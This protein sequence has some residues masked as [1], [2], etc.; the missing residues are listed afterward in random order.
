MPLSDA[1]PP[2]ETAEERAARVRAAVDGLLR[3]WADGEAIDFEAALAAQPDLMPE[4][5][6]QVRA[7][8]LLA[9]AERQAASATADATSAAAS[10]AAASSA[11]T[12]WADGASSVDAVDA[13]ERAGRAGAAPL[14][15]GRRRA[16]LAAASTLHAAELPPDSGLRIRCPHCR[17]QVEVLDEH[18]WD[19]I[20][21]GTCGSVFSLVNSAPA[22]DHVQPLKVLGHFELVSRLGVGSFGSVWQARDVELDRLVAV[23]IPRRGQ[24][25]PLG[26]AQFLREARVAAQLRHP[27]IVRVYEVGRDGDLLYIVSD[28]VRG[29]TLTQWLEQRRPTVREAAA[30]AATIADALEHAHQQG[31][32][33]RDLKPANILIDEQGAPQITDFG[34]AK[35][36]VGEVTMTA[37]GQIL[38]TP[39]YMSP[40]QAAGEGH[41]VDR[42]ADL[43]A[44]GVVL[45]EMLTGELP[46]R[47]S[48]QRQLQQKLADAA[49]SAR[50]LDR[51]IPRD[52]DV[53]CARCLDREPPRRFATAAALA[54]DL[55]RFLR[56]EPIRARPLPRLERAWRWSR[57]RPAAAAAA[58]LTALLAVGG[59]LAAWR[60]DRQRD[61]L[62]EL[63]RQKTGLIADRDAAL[64][65]A[66][67][68]V[69]DADDRADQLARQLAALREGADPGSPAPARPAGEPQRELLARLVASGTP[70]AEAAAGA[71]AADADAAGNVA[72]DADA[73]R[74][75][76]HLALAWGLAWE[77]L[78]QP[79]RAADHYRRAEQSLAALAALAP[80]DPQVARTLADCY[81]RLAALTFVHDREAA[82]AYLQRRGALATRFARASR[83]PRWQAAAADA[84]LRQATAGAAAEAGPALRQAAEFEQR[85]VQAAPLAAAD[86]YA[87][88]CQLCQVEPLLGETAGE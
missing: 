29:V 81:A 32:V 11:A 1:N 58:A 10:A 14:A 12:S 19:R 49:P 27:N 31:V 53:I 72:A 71:D 59:P 37:D 13:A 43:Y 16:S 60:I 68:Q 75:A 66:R 5:A 33:H 70:P 83:D 88:A 36:D 54:A 23:K 86:W 34:L 56:G 20:A 87:L 82:R 3:R 78:E 74:G 57:R 63:N 39:A 73:L 80:D 8:R 44:A 22:T 85:L 30:L 79:D 38:G 4:L 84:A 47:G 67:R 45:F 15:A 77:A 7:V 48:V 18:A 35:R 65:A 6:D 61:A 2:P 41:H 26:E 51:M 55:R 21:C 42:R 52:L 24:L 64:A 17:Y 28:L 25:D 9:E 76:C 69:A 46:F 50:S 40:E 62:S